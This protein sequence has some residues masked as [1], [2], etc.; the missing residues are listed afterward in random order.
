MDELSNEVLWHWVPVKGLKQRL[1]GSF[2]L[3]A[4]N[5]IHAP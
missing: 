5:R 4:G 3:P 1:S 2:A